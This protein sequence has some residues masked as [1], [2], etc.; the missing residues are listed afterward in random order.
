MNTRSKNTDYMIFQFVKVAMYC[1]IPSA[2]L[3]ITITVAL[4]FVNSRTTSSI[5]AMVLMQQSVPVLFSYGLLPLLIFALT[6]KSKLEVVGLKR[7]RHFLITVLNICAAIIFICYLFYK[8][9]PQRKE[10]V[11]VIHYF[12][13]D[14]AEEIL[15]RGIIFYQLERLV[16]RRWISV[17][18]CAFIFA[19][20]FHSTDG[21]W[22]NIAYRVPFG[23]I[24]SMLYL[25]TGSLMTSVN[26]HWIY[27][28]ILTINYI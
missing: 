7:N 22:M 4:T 24:A 5:Y 19:L 1:C 23:I 28:V 12:C 18:I 3:V 9:I 2:V 13:V 17:V 10:F 11:Y 26:F 20:V 15:V 8:N 6:E 25:M 21:I 14:L 16:K 27:N